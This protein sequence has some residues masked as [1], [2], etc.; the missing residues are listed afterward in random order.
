M[1]DDAIWLFQTI[2]YLLQLTEATLKIGY[3][4]SLLRSVLYNIESFAIIRNNVVTES[5]TRG[6]TLNQDICQLVFAPFAGYLTALVSSDVGLPVSTV[7][8]G[9]AI[10]VFASCTARYFVSLFA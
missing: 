4:D 1:S 10:L 5:P 3:K 8:L 6:S 7:A 2:D 9:L